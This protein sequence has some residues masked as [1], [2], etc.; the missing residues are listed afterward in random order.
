[1]L[2]GV[3][4][5]AVPI[6]KSRV[7]GQDG[8]PF[9]RELRGKRV[10]HL[11]YRVG[12]AGNGGAGQFHHGRVQRI[13]HHRRVTDIEADVLARD[14]INNV[15]RMLPIDMT[16]HDIEQRGPSHDGITGTAVAVVAVADEQRFDLQLLAQVVDVQPEFLD[17]P[18]R[19]FHNVYAGVSIFH[20]ASVFS[21]CRLAYLF[22][23]G[24][25]FM[26]T[27]HQ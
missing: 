15:A 21:T 14:R 13:V 7:C 9:R 8:D 23:S 2:E 1:M 12:L 3:P 11:G 18:H 24:T 25:L 19:S 5:D 26:S 17:E 16:I 4:E 20:N 10:V 27:R 6:L 22:A